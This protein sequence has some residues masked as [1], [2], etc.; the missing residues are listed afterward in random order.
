MIPDFVEHR[1]IRDLLRSPQQPERAVVAR[2]GAAHARVQSADGLDVVVE[3]LG[4]R[5]EHR[6]ERLLLDAEEVGRQ[7]LDR[8]LG[9]LRL[10]RADRR[11]VVSRA[12]VGDVVSVD[13]GDDDVLE[14]HLRGRLGE[15]QRL[16]RVRRRLG[17]ARMD[18]AVAARAGARVAED[19]EG[20]SAAPPALRDVRAARFL[21]DRVQREPVYELLDIEVRAVLRRRSHL[22]PLGPARP[23]GDGKR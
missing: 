8:C 14:L 3:D 20:R 6:L 4:P 11:R 17:L 22:H 9:E 5:G 7:N 10:E 12:A 23:L 18:V 15:P 2:L 1:I 19:L 21:A 13:R 16:E